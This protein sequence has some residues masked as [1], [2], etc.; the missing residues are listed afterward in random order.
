M[1]PPGHQEGWFLVTH[2]AAQKAASVAAWG[3]HRFHC[4]Q[5][6]SRALETN[7]SAPASR[8]RP[9]RRTRLALADRANAA[10]VNAG[11]GRFARRAAAGADYSPFGGTM[12][13]FFKW[14]RGL[15][16]LAFG[17]GTRA[18]WV[19]VRCGPARGID[20]VRSTGQVPGGPGLLNSVTLTGQCGDQR[21]RC[22]GPLHR[23]F[24][25]ETCLM[26]HV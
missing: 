1:K 3:G 14:G 21:L 10:R 16:A 2:R 11:R 9:S 6:T 7:S 5:R 25:M 17:W 22:Q 8:S 24:S 13:V 18:R 26:T 23:N 12:A 15:A 4:K 20:A 19:V